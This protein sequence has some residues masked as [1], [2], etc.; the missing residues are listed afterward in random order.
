MSK[1]VRS[2][3]DLLTLI[4]IAIVAYAISNIAHEGLGHGGACLLVGC[5]PH[6]LTTMQF[7]GDETQLSS[8][9]V[10]IIAAGGSIV[11]LL[12]AGAGA[13][14]LNRARIDR[15]NG[16]FFLWLLTSISLL[17]ATGYLL[18]SGVG[19][20]GDW[21]VVTSGLPGGVAWKFALIAAGAV[22]YW[23]AVRWSMRRLGIH[24]REQVPARVREAYGYTLPAYFTG[25]ALAIVAG[26]FDPA[27]QAIILIAGVAASMGGTSGLA[28]GPQQLRNPVFAPAVQPLAPIERS[29]TW[30]AFGVVCAAVFVL[31]LGP[32]VRFG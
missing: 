16:W 14:L 19:N 20:V 5:K 27:A 11:N 6:L 30:I 8:A 2:R 25:A 31:V 24:L 22:S 1:A 32:G 21:V 13:L 4:A 3:P 28:W 29:W 12:L 7:D 18:F 10:R 26:V 17:Q 15:P 9:A 23:L